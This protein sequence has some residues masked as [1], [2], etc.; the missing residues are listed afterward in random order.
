MSNNKFPRG[1]E[2]R[3]WDL[4]IHSP[5]TFL[6]NNYNKNWDDFIKEI[7]KNDIVG[8]GLTNYFC[9]DVEEI[10]KTRR[11]LPNRIVLPAIEFRI[12]Q[13]N[14]NDEFINIHIIF[15]ESTDLNKIVQSLNRVPLINTSE[16]KTQYYCNEKDIRNIGFDNTLVETTNLLEQL[17]KDFDNGEYLIATCPRGYGN[18]RP[19][20]GDGR[21]IALAIEIDKIS[22]L[23]F[24][25]V[26]DVDFFLKKDRYPNSQPKPVLY[27]SD[28]HSIEEIGKK[29]TWIKSDPTFEGLKQILYEPDDR[30]KISETVPEIKDNYLVINRVKFNDTTSK[31]FS[32][33]W[34]YLNQNLNS[35]IGGK[36]SGKSLLLY[37]IAKTI[38]PA[39]IEEINDED[40]FLT[41]NYEFDDIPDFDFV[42][43]WG[44]EKRYTLKNNLEEKTRQITF[45]PQLYLNNLAEQK[46]AE[47]NKIV[48]D[49]LKDNIDYYHFRMEQEDK[50]NKCN[51]KICVEIGNLFQNYHHLQALKEELKELGDKS[52]IIKSIE[53]NKTLFEDLKIKMA[54]S[55]EETVLY[56]YTRDETSNYNLI[57]KSLDNDYEF[58]SELSKLIENIKNNYYPE[59]INAYFT[60]LGYKFEG[61]DIKSQLLKLIQ[62]NLIIDFNN[63]IDKYFS[64]YSSHQTLLINRMLYVES[65]IKGL[66]EKIEHIIKKLSQKDQYNIL[67]NKIEEEQSYLSKIEKKQKEIDVQQKKISPKFIVSL[68]K[69]LFDLYK[70]IIDKTNTYSES[71]NYD[72]Q[73]VSKLT[74]KE[75]DFNSLFSDSITKN[76]SLEKQFNGIFKG[77][78]YS[79]NLE[80]HLANIEY[81][82]DILIKE[83]NIKFN[84]GYDQQKVT[85][86]L[87]DDYFSVYFDIIQH[88][89]SLL[90]MSPGK[91][92]IILFQLF[93]HLSSSRYPILIDQPEDSL[94]N[95]TVFLELNDFIKKKKID[96]QIIIVSHNPNLVVS[97][98]SENV[99]V[100]NQDGQNK[101]SYKRKYQFEY[102][103]GG[104]ENSFLNEEENA[105]LYQKGIREHIC[106]ILEGGREA[107][108]KRENKYGFK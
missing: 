87:F 105:I 26:Q 53:N 32:N 103:S 98:D 25:T 67:E 41:Y 84:K 95:R 49:I 108:E 69:G 54:L 4:H 101:E 22:N 80:R 16:T 28:A 71:T 93:L 34:I 35:I 20:K 44:D 45:I 60:D 21:G 65:K 17:K 31:Y 14:K 15:S 74:F 13:P 52:A 37:H 43:E 104:I 89:D 51:Q 5:N 30:L 79:F 77:N 59:F 64:K 11:C 82:F 94:D 57:T 76:I 18:F 2:W 36:S 29:Y 27:S 7:I 61:D 23:L 92:G 90:K 68:Y 107:F 78:T 10:E 33:E 3:K 39:R 63:T 66:N 48:E 102:I 56:N 24:G 58:Y 106:E 85:Y 42:V 97:T 91:R 86:I 100:A 38:D 72:F 99:I 88:G 8:I 83:E 62:N 40:S 9:I 96:R 1:S 47:L 73:L 50:I 19:Q 12:K 81:I 55:E 70:E 46:R 6:N 75:S